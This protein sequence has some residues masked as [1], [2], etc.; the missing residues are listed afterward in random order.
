ML[1]ENEE[2]SYEAATEFFAGRDPVVIP[3]YKI[4]LQGYHVFALIY[5]INKDMDLESFVLKNIH[6][7]LKTKNA[8]ADFCTIRV[9][10]VY[11]MIC[12]ITNYGTDWLSPDGIQGFDKYV[13]LTIKPFL[14]EQPTWI[15]PPQP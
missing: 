5:P 11:L 4:Q 13:D 1:Y 15:F 10:T 12:L 6:P 9:G 2:T 7:F 3:P 14:Q 8:M